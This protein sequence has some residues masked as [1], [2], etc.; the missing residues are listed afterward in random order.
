MMKK[1]GLLFASALLTATFSVAPAAAQ[2]RDDCDLIIEF[3][4]DSTREARSCAGSGGIC[5]DW[6]WECDGQPYPAYFADHRAEP[7]H[8]VE[9][10]HLLTGVDPTVL[11]DD[12]RL[13]SGLDAQLALATPFCPSRNLFERLDRRQKPTR[14]DKAHKPEPAVNS[15]AAA[16]VA[17]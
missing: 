17:P 14:P 3:Y 9:P 4:P 16:L 11:R 6:Y 10:R 8:L 2:P 1:I 15:V 5:L 12:S 7:G 13:P